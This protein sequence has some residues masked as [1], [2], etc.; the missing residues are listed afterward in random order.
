MVK[1]SNTLQGH[2]IHTVDS[3]FNENSKNKKKIARDMVIFWEGRPN[4]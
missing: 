2:E 3:P 4:I 1:L